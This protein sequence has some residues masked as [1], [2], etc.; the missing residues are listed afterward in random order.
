[1]EFNCRSTKPVKRLPMLYWGKVAEMLRYVR[2]TA[3]SHCQ[4]FY[5]TRAQ[6]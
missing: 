2:H 4:R 6:R 3:G 5:P 1:M